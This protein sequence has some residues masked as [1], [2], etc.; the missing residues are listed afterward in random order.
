MYGY[1]HSVR[2]N[3]SFS[4]TELFQLFWTSLAFGFALSFRK[5]GVG[6][7]VDVPVGVVNLLFATV[8][9][10]LCMYIHVSLQRL[11]AIKLGYKATYSYWLNAVLFTVF[12]AFL[13]FGYIPF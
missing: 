8:V 3:F 4:R 11:V 9:V 1:W 5:W 7:T 6:E 10:L 2:E 12:L 13:T